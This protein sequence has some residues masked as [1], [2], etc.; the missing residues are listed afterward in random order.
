MPFIAKLCLKL[1]I[2]LSYWSLIVFEE[3]MDAAHMYQ[4]DARMNI[5][6]KSSQSA[7]ST[8][9]FEMPYFAESRQSLGFF[10]ILFFVRAIFTFCTGAKI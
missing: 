9:H 4:S 10:I 3:H 6:V 8:S 1:E 7:R 5:A 2:L